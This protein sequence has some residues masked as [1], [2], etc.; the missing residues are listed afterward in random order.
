MTNTKKRNKLL[1]GMKMMMRD[2]KL[3]HM[4]EPLKNYMRLYSRSKGS[5]MLRIRI[6]VKGA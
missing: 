2:W 1:W 5:T 4:R 6:R 3:F